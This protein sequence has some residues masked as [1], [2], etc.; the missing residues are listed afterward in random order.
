M[1]TR[2]IFEIQS[3]KIGLVVYYVASEKA[4]YVVKDYATCWCYTAVALGQSHRCSN[5]TKIIARR[6]GMN[7]GS[8]LVTGTT[9]GYRYF[10]ELVRDSLDN[11]R[12]IYGVEER[13]ERVYP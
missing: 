12:F 6:T 7:E 8:L 2:K 3:K 5:K 13:M 9:G 1:Q 10:R 11:P 4:L